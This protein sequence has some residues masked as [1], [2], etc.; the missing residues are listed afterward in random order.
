MAPKLAD[1]GF[2]GVSSS[3]RSFL[4]ALSGSSSSNG[5]PKLKVSTFRGMPSLWISDDEILA[6]A[7]PFQFSLVGFFPSKRPSLDYIRKFFFNLKLNGEV[8][9]TLLDSSH[10]LIKLENDLDY[11]RI[12]CH[13]SYLVFNCFMKL[14]KWSPSVDIGV[15]SPVIPIW[16]SFP[17]LRPH[18]FAP[19]ILHGL[20]SIFGKPLKIDSATSLGS[21]P[22][23][24]RVLVKLDIT[25]SYPDRIW[26]GSEKLGYVQDVVMDEFPSFCGSCRCF[27]HAMGECRSKNIVLETSV[28]PKNVEH[29]VKKGDFPISVCGGR[30]IP[31]DGTSGSMD[32]L[33]ALNSSDTLPLLN[34]YNLENGVNVVS[35]GHA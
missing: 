8:S 1:P 31:V 24:A 2:L 7:V 23:L 19:K 9:V 18:L 15:E 4:Q 14:T 29:D 11:C 12:F 34:V 21:R 5:F 16:V 20:A 35:D 27:G 30:P 33:A 32:P 17:S 28:L 3:S 6:L 26:L 22:S 13:R 10:I 25:K